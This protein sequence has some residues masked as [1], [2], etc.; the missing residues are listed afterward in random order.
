MEDWFE[1]W[2][3]DRQSMI[4]TMIRN[5]V[6]DIEAGYNPAGACIMR[7]NSAIT[8]FK[9]QFDRDVEHLREMT[10][11]AADRWCYIDMKKRGVIS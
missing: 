9:A 10:E 8:E 2:F 7:Q 6:A 1:I 4:E 11:K 5:M 3:A